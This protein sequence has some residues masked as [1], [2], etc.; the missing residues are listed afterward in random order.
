VANDAQV[1]ARTVREYYTVLEDTLIGRMLEPIQQIGSRK[2]VSKA[3]FYFFDTGIVHQL[4]KVLSL[5]A[6]SPGYGDAFESFIFHELSSYLDYHN[7]KES[8]NFW[9]TSTGVEV[10][11][12]IGE[13]IAI[14]VKASQSVDSR[15]LKGLK[16]DVINLFE[17]P[18]NVVMFFT[19]KLNSTKITKRSYYQQ[20]ILK[21]FLL[22]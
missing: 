7:K 15:D 11:F 2:V 12:I 20:L 13:K 14:E 3:K 19:V 18:T 10:D 4:Q 9:R 17:L 6:M 5:P 21:N 8:L 16:T 1:P 22:F